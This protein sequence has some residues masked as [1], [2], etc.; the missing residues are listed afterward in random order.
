ML[1]LLLLLLHLCRWLDGDAGL[2]WG[3]GGGGLGLLL[4]Q[5]G[6]GNLDGRAARGDHGLGRGGP[7]HHVVGPGRRLLLLLLLMRHLLR[8]LL[9]QLLLLLDLLR[10]HVELPGVRRRPARNVAWPWRLLAGERPTV[11]RWKGAAT[12]GL[13]VGR[14]PGCSSQ[15]QVLRRRVGQG[16]GATAWPRTGAD[17]GAV[18]GQRLGP[19]LLVVRWVVVLLL[20]LLGGGGGGGGG[21]GLVGQEGARLKQDQ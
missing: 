2:G 10:R 9:L 19:L 1:L 4:P 7:H 14:S 3:G 5:P 6:G 16:A 11:L 18:E 13:A 8:H 20:L 17:G 21:R 12:D 15:G